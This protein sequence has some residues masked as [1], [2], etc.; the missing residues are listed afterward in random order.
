[1]IASSMIYSEDILNNTWQILFSMDHMDA[2]P[3]LSH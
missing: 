2:F 1:M 3:S